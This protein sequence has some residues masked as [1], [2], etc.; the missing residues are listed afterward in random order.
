M[1]YL[2]GNIKIKGSLK[3][4]GRFNPKLFPAPT[5]ENITKYSQAKL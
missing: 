3:K 5:P 1:G 4:A 2:K